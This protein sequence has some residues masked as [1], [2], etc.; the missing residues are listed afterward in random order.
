M[1]IIEQFDYLS[2]EIRALKPEYIQKAIQSWQI[3]PQVKVLTLEMVQELKGKNIIL[4][5]E[6]VCRLFAEAHLK[7]EQVEFDSVF[8]RWD[9]TNTKKEKKVGPEK[10]ITKNDFLNSAFKESEKSSDWW[11]S[12][13]AVI[14]KD[15]EVILSAHNTHLPSPHTPYAEGDPRNVSHKGE[16]LELFTSIHAEARLVADA[17]K[18]GISLEGTE[19]YVTDFPC[20]VCAKQVAFAGI[21][22]LY[23][24][25]G[26]AVLDGERIL[27]QKGI[28]IIKIEE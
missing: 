11:R 19:M 2:K 27:K 22:K 28:E 10:I 8:L 5:D 16:D 18:Q 14:V 9:R 26:Y 17:A 3:I 1:D 24:N 4:P 25:R 15:G 6:D 21:K 20:P 23:F 12:V 13:G 7:G